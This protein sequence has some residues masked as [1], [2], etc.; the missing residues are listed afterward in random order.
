MLLQVNKI[1]VYT[2]TLNKCHNDIKYEAVLYNIVSFKI[3]VP[4]DLNS[5]TLVHKLLN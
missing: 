2:D 4:L 1:K 5:L 3:L